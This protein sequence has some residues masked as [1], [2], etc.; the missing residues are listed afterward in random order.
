MYSPVKYTFFFLLVLL[1][2]FAAHIGIL[3]AL[4]LPLF[5]DKIIVSYIV[6]GAMA[7]VIVLVLYMLRKKYKH[8]LGFLFLGG[9]LL[10]FAVF[11]IFFYPYFHADDIL[12]RTEF[13]SFFVP[14]AASL[15]LETIFLSK[16]LNNL[17]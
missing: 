16:M 12:S 1:V 8:Q 11:F 7:I 6:N 14:Y 13:F 4:A 2:V 3:H 10:K 5:Q 17:Q 15:T 9:S